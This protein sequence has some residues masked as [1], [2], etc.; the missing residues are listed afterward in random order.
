[1]ARGAGGQAP[2]TI[3]S[4]IDDC[5]FGSSAGLEPGT[6]RP[7]GRRYSPENIAALM[8]PRDENALLM[9]RMEDSNPRQL[10]RITNMLVKVRNWALA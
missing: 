5:G 1:M 4:E 8:A 2:G 3:Q 6:C 9:Q 10:W 7:K